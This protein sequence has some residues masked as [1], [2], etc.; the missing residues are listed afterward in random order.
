[1]VGQWHAHFLGTHVKR[2]S[3]N[4]SRPNSGPYAYGT[5]Y[6][7]PE[8]L[9]SMILNAPMR[10][11]DDEPSICS[12]KWAG[13]GTGHYLWLGGRGSESNEF[14]WKIF[15]WPTR[16]GKKKF[17]YFSMPTLWTSKYFRRPPLLTPFDYI[18]WVTT[19]EVWMEGEGVMGSSLTYPY[20]SGPSAPRATAL[21]CSAFG[22]GLSREI[23]QG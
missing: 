15:S 1:M 5:H 22:V 11:M 16:R 7:W 23:Y 21:S 10:R 12:D 4:S 6:F 14:L 3:L 2:V 20:F 13:L 18:F 9:G 17:N 19:K 8:G